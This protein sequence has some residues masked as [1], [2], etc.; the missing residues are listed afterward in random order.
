MPQKNILLSIGTFKE[1]I[2]FLPFAKKLVDLGF[3]L[4]G[5]SGTADYM[6]ENKVTIQVYNFQFIFL[7]Y[8]L[9]ISC[10]STGSSLLP[11]TLSIYM[12]LFDVFI[13]F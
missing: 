9:S 11:R 6:S 10:T 12:Y 1:K 13:I 4:Y 5:T 3:T 8:P 2:E 7:Y